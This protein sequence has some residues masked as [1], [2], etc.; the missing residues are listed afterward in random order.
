MI[1]LHRIFNIL[2]SISIILAGICFIAGCLSIY[3]T[4]A[5][6]PYSREIVAETFSHIAIPVYICLA[7]TIIGFIWELLLPLKPQKQK[8]GKAYAQTLERLLAK[9]DMNQCDKN[10]LSSIYNERKYRRLHVTIRT[11]FLCIG[12]IVFLSYALN[13]TNWPK[14]AE[15]TTAM[16]HAMWM[17]IPC[18]GIP[19]IYAIIAA[20]C[21]D[22]SLQR[23]IELIK[24]V[25]TLSNKQKEDASSDA[26]NNEQERILR[27]SLLLVGIGVLIYGYISGGTLDVLTKAINICTECIGLG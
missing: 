6:K 19:F 22:K 20:Y 27:Y 3:Y 15:I 1:R 2:L 14:A 18:M 7:F 11:V 5:D 17:L 13:G 10:L 25:P 16:I 23:E 21:N 24:P 9:K 8:P 26:S 12:S 4:G